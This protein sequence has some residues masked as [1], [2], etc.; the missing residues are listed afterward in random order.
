[1]PLDVDLKPIFLT[2]ESPLPAVKVFWVSI[3]RGDRM[4]RQAL[5]YFRVQQPAVPAT[6]PEPQRKSVC[7]FLQP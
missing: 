1:M 7:E 2:L 3:R 5:C 6:T 4:G